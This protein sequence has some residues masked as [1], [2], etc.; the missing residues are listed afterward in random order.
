M[1]TS[2]AADAAETDKPQISVVMVTRNVER[3]LGESIE[4]ILGQTFQN[5]EFVI[6]DFGSTDNSPSIVSR[7]AAVDTRIKFHVIP[8][9]GLAEARNQSC[10]LARGQ[11]IAIMDAD[12]VALPNRLLWEAEFM[13]NRPNVGVVG[14]AVEWINSAGKPLLI[15][16]NPS[17]NSELQ[18]ALLTH[19]AVWQPTALIRT[20]AFALAGQYRGAFAPA[21]DYD[22]WLRIAERYEIANLE[23]VVLKYRI[24]PHQVS[25]QKCAQQTL[26]I[27]GA[28]ASALAR[29]LGKPDPLAS[30]QELTSQLLLSIGVTETR[31]QAELATNFRKWVEHMDRAGECAVALS[32]AL[33]FL[34]SHADHAERQQVANIK[35]LVGK[36]WWRQKQFARGM[37]AIAQAIIM[38]PAIS[39]RLLKGMFR[40]IGR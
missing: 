14:G 30:V 8:G 36:L 38:W 17:G 33:Q 24:H 25:M 3:F 31:Q 15:A 21:E 34:E 19:S 13:V 18:A 10:L 5:F 2:V 39:G 9:C 35:L 1:T 22:L 23:Q 16:R 37:L 12:D 26:G 40:R 7:Y 20:E 32:G 4:S 6:V 27:L 28:Q 11:Y 29:R